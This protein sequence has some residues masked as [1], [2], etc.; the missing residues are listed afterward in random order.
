MTINSTKTYLLSVL[1][2][3]IILS[4]CSKTVRFETSSVVPAAVAKIKLSKDQ[5]QNNLVE[6]TVTGL[7]DPE[8]LSPSR[9]T[10]VVWME[11]K[12]AIRNVGQLKS[13]TSYFSSARKAT[14]KAVTPFKPLRFFVTAENNP[15]IARP[16]GQTV[17]T[18]E[19]L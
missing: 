10:Y 3:I 14:L 17:L 12:D 6:M 2:F 8:R 13:E 19:K 18:T 5:N 7:A 15:G 9:K 11:T 16:S 1:S 4:S